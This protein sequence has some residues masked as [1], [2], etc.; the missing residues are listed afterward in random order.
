M[1]QN[2][3]CI[4]AQNKVGR[5]PLYEVVKVDGSTEATRCLLAHG[6]DPHI[7]D[8][9][10]NTVLHEAVDF[11]ALEEV[12]LL[13]RAGCDANKQNKS[14]LTA[15]HVVLVNM[16]E[17]EQK[18]VWERNHTLKIAL[19]LL[20]HTDIDIKDA[21]NRTPLRILSDAL[22][23][24][25]KRMYETQGICALFQ[26]L[27]KRNCDPNCQDVQGNTALHGFAESISPELAP[28]AS[29]LLEYGTDIAIH[30]KQGKSFYSMFCKYPSLKHYMPQEMWHALQLPSL[31]CLSVHAVY[32][33][34]ERVMLFPCIPR[35]V[36]DY[37]NIP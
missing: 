20:N 22:V 10:G 13:L 25:F 23:L 36:K 34:R 29:Q 9:N 3:A 16:A 5:T 18:S 12:K 30:N 1:L 19:E 28:F 4:N 24:Y 27:L 32:P 33:I 8:E 26:E 17:D 21:Q 7:V 15:L 31:F 11:M 37:L 14:G 6:A 2:G 35:I